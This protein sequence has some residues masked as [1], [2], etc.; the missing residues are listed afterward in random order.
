M[1]E[2]DTQSVLI[3][4]LLIEDKL[5][6]Y[7]LPELSIECFRQDL[8]PTFAAVQG[9]WTS[10][11]KLDAVQIIARYPAEKQ[12]VLSCVQLCESECVRLTRERVEEWTRTILE[13]AAK[14]RFQQ[15]A[16]QAVGASV[17]YADLPDLYQQMGEA[18][19]VS[20]EKGDFKS[21]GE[22]IDDYIRKLDEKPR[23]FK[24][25]ISS[26]DNTLHLARGNYFLIGGRPSAG[27]T[28][29]SLQIAANMAQAGHC[30]CYFS[31][32]TDEKTL[33]E[34][35]IANRL[36]APLH[37][38]KNKTVSMNDLDRL[39]DCK[40]Y[41]LYIRSAAGQGVAWMKNFFNTA[42][43]DTIGECLSG[44]KLL[45]AS[46]DAKGNT[47]LTFES[48]YE[49]YSDLLTIMPDGSVIGTFICDEEQRPQTVNDNPTMT[50]VATL[51]EDK[52]LS[53]MCSTS[54]M[55]AEDPSEGMELTF[56]DYNGKNPDTLL[57]IT[58]ALVDGTPIIKVETQSLN[59]Q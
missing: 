44:E 53:L 1:M 10:T 9:F 36:Y 31:L 19:N 42:S 58:P 54:G 50:D 45:N 56:L 6:P 17:S 25:G 20:T 43:T 14:D 51:L 59:Q 37:A 8:R 38:V 39:A 24:T 26:L 12:T 15:L 22:C 33:T 16:M 29:L 11:G 32:E 47:L 2:L 28:A 5:A 21:L 52:K 30:V 18:L 46:R 49:G 40:K 55:E 27:K 13:S 48:A 4:A 41:K 57:R 7:A 35:L 23:Y 3:G 34:R